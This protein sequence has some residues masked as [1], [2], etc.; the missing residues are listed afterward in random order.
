MRHVHADIST[1]KPANWVN[2]G[3]GYNGTALVGAAFRLGCGQVTDKNRHR[4]RNGKGE[5]EKGNIGA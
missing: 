3:T 4:I 5:G 1:L 2:A